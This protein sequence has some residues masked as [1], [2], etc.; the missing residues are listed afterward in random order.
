MDNKKLLRRSYQKKF[1]ALKKAIIERPPQGWLKTIRE[2]LGMT[3]TQL[4]KKINV[5]QPRVIN[6]EKNEKNT[7]ISTM[8][9]IADA[10]NCD[11]VYAFIPRENIDDI[12]YNQAKKK[13]LKIL[14]K[15]H[16]NMSLEN[17]LTDSDDLV[18]D[19]IKDLLDDNISR[20]W[21]EG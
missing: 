19:I 9:R 6:L 12:I 7:K 10:L 8:E 16:T 11:F 5:A 17:Q 18:E 3:T 4:A 1:N 21:D 13:A 2:F 14:N 15:V 20:I